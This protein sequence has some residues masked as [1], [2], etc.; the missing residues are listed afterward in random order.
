MERRLHEVNFT[1]FRS[2]MVSKPVLTRLRN[3]C[4]LSSHLSMES[5]MDQSI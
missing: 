2:I 4:S 5:K 1:V 3:S